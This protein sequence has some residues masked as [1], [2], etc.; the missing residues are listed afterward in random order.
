MQ[1]KIFSISFPDTPGYSEICAD[2]CPH[3]KDRFAPLCMLEIPFW[4]TDV[5]FSYKNSCISTK[6]KFIL[7]FSSFAC[8]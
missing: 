3:L 7:D 5:C 4:N 2:N 6:N 8:I 1:A